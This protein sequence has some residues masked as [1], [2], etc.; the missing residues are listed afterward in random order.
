LII[1]NAGSFGSSITI[2]SATADALTFNQTANDLSLGG[3]I[4]GAGAMTKTG[5]GT[6]T[7]N[8]A[9]N[10]TGLTTIEEG[11]Y[12]GLN[13]Q[14]TLRLDFNAAGAPLNNIINNGADNSALYLG[15]STSSAAR[16]ALGGGILAINGSSAASV[17]NIQQFNGTTFGIGA[18]S[19]SI[20]NN[21]PTS[22]VKVSLG[23]LTR[24]PA[25]TVNFGQPTQ[26]TISATNGF[27]TASG[28]ASKILTDVNG[29]A[30]GVVGGTDWAAKDSGN[31]FVVSLSTIPGGYSAFSANGPLTANANIDVT[32]T[33][34]LTASSAATINSLRFNGG[35]S[36]PTTLSLTG[37]NTITTGGILFGS[38][39]ITA[40]TIQGGTIR[41]G[42]TGKELVIQN[43]SS[44][45][46]VISS[47]IADNGTTAVTLQAFNSTIGTGE[48][49]LTGANTYTGSTYITSG[50]ITSG[51][52][53]RPFGSSNLG[54]SVVIDGNTNAQYYQ[55][56]KISLSNQFFVVGAGWNET[57]GPNGVL[58]LDAG[59]ITGPVTML[60]D[61]TFGAV[62][63]TGTISGQIS[64]AYNLTKVGA[65]TLI[66]G[67][68][69]SFPNTYT[70]ATTVAA[71]TLDASSPGALPG[72]D[73]PGKAIVAGGATL[74]AAPG[75]STFHWT[76]ANIDTLRRNAAFAAGA[77][78]GID[79]SFFSPF[80]YGNISDSGNGPLGLVKLGAGILSL[81]ADTYSGGTTINAGTLQLT[82]VG[83]M[84]SPS[85]GLAL[86]GGVLD[87]NGISASVGAV[88]GGSGT[89]LNNATGTHATLTIGAA[90]FSGN[91]ASVIADNSS[92]TGT[93]RVSKVGAGVVN[94]QGV[95]TYSGGTS[96]SGGVLAVNGNT[97]SLNAASTLDF[98]NTGG[99]LYQGNTT[100]SS[101][102]FGALTLDAGDATVQSNYGGSGNTSL[103]FSSLT[104]TSGASGLLLATGGANGISNKI[105]L[106][107]AAPNALVDPGVFFGAGGGI[108]FAWCDP[109]GFVR[110]IS[111][112]TD[113]GSSTSAGSA[114]VS[115][116]YIQT[117]GPVTAQTTESL[118]TL[119][120]SGANDFTLADGASLTVAAILKTGDNGA[121][122]SGGA[123]IQAPGNGELVIR[124]GQPGDTL[125]ISTPIV[126]S[127][128]NALTV[129]GAGTLALNV[130]TSYSGATN[131]NN[132][133]LRLGNPGAVQNSTLILNNSSVLTFAPSIGTFTAGGLAGPGNFSLTDTDGGAV[134]LV[135]GGN[136][137]NTNFSGSMKGS[138]TLTK[139]GSGSLTLSGPNGYVGGTTV[140]GGMIVI[141]SDAIGTAAGTPAPLGALPAAG[142][143]ANN[144]VLNGGT[145]EANATF[146]INTQRGIGLGPAT[147]AVGGAGTIGV[148]A[149]NTL[150]Y[151]GTITTAGNTG[152]NQLAK[153]DL[154]TLVLS[155]SNSYTGGTMILGGTLVAGPDVTGAMTGAPAP[156][157]ALPAGPLGANNIILSGGTLQASTTYTLNA[158]RGIGLGPTTGTIGGSGT[159]DVA[160]G[161]TLTY[162]GAISS[163]G[164][165]GANQLTKADAGTLILGGPNTYTG[166]TNVQSGTLIF[167]SNAAIP[168]AGSPTVTVQNG[169]VVA[170]GSPIDQTFLSSITNTSSGFVALN[171]DSSGS[172][173]FSAAGANL[174]NVSLGAFSGSWTY[175]GAITPNN[176]N[177]R[178][179]GGGGVLTVNS[180]LSGANGLIV[181][182][183]GGAVLG[184]SANSFSGGITINSGATLGFATDGT[185]TGVDTP[186][187]AV[188]LALTS[189]IVI[190]NGTLQ[191]TG[192]SVVLNANR[193]IAVPDSIN[194]FSFSA[195]LTPS[196]I[197]TIDVAPSSQLTIPGAISGGGAL[198][199]TGL[200]TLILSGPNTYTGGTIV[201]AGTLT[202]AGGG[203]LGSPLSTFPA[204]TVNSS[205]SVSSA[206]NLSGDTVITALNGTVSGTGTAT[207]NVPA[208]S[209][210]TISQNYVASSTYAGT[211]AGAGGLTISGSGSF[212]V[213]LGASTYTG[214]TTVAGGIFEVTGG[215][216]L[217]SSTLIL[218]GGYINDTS[219]QMFSSTTLVQ[220][221]SSVVLRG[222]FGPIIRAMNRGGTPAGSALDVTGTTGGITTTTANTAGSILGGWATMGED[223]AVSAGDGM[224]AGA[225]TPLATYIANTWAPG[226]NVNVS[227]SNS[228]LPGSTT[229]SLN[230]RTSGAFTVTLS[231][232]NTIT[233]GGI[234]SSPA[235]GNNPSTITG[236]TLTS[237]NGTDLV[238]NQ[239]NNYSA[240]SP[241]IINSVI[242]GN[243]GL[244][245]A[246]NG[247]LILGGAN[248]YTG[249]T[250]IG[251]GTV[252][253]SSESA[254][255]GSLGTPPTAATASYSTGGIIING[256]ANQNNAGGALQAK[257]NITLDPNR[258]IYLGSVT[259]YGVGTID[260]TG[261]NTLSFGGVITN[262]VGSATTGVGTLIKA[263]TG[264]LNITGA[265]NTYSGGTIVV[266]GTLIARPD[267]TSTT[268]GTPAP[269]GA[270]PAPGLGA[271]NIAL[272]GGTLEADTTY[273][274]NALRGIGL[275]WRIGP[276][277]NG[278]GTIDVTSG[279]TLTFNGTITENSIVSF[280]P[281][282]LVKTDAGT[283]ILGG[284]NIYSGG[285]TV[286]GGTLRTTATGT[287]GSSSGPLV[288]SA[289]AGV[290]ST[291]SLGNSQTVSQLSGT[292][293]AGGS[294][295]INVAA[296]T[297]FAVNQSTQTTFSG[298]L[299]NSGT[300]TMSSSGSGRLEFTGTP[301]F[302]E[303]SLLTVTGG[304]L[305]FNVVSGSPTIGAGV[306]ATVSGSATLE[307]A[308]SVSALSSGATRVNITNNSAIPGVLASGTHQQVG[309]IDGTGAT[310][311]NAGSDLTANHIIQSALVIGGA[312]GS[313]GL[314]TIDASDASG[315]PLDQSSGLALAGPLTPNAPFGTDGIS[316][317]DL[318]RASGA[319]FA[320]M[321]PEDSVGVGN[322]SP[323]PEPSTLLLMLLAV[324]CVVGAQFVRHQSAV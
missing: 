74:A 110:A 143:G 47:I 288:V 276:T 28:T 3:T 245:K 164:N 217:A 157:G 225:V 94:F 232:N 48:I 202:V 323:V 256:N 75:S 182:A 279:N 166:G 254:T 198:R 273:T 302:S 179:G 306:A 91:F 283:L 159:I 219:T 250:Y 144:I 73:T 43:L 223:W 271:N 77:N 139:I 165:S 135:V 6:L 97:G 257:A 262:N 35:G 5:Y 98:G 158:L 195:L 204:L 24:K 62:N 9:T 154:G 294:A 282:A 278:A 163:A 76:S 310:Q 147:G 224:S 186:L 215:Y 230:F 127:G 37:T 261:A 140:L 251:C 203:T 50:R 20:T 120:V 90:N 171:A 21:N 66:F 17:N 319:D 292:V 233:S 54:T 36:T 156:L 87:L 88:A 71:G 213:L 86:N 322:L 299:V 318:S 92:G 112:G 173:D 119:N 293:G 212:Q 31:A 82:A 170:A 266:G 269:L 121:L 134:V 8:A 1:G 136:N 123:A 243:I 125:S 308:G 103:T 72:Y 307:L 155:G 239:E 101:Q 83:A 79:T 38:G 115:G 309:N 226:N 169:A 268:P 287:I 100:G 317:A 321:S 263:N 205:N 199:K 142:L 197:A 286:N 117:T 34:T 40:P 228:P 168:N 108:D 264:V 114:S 18:S 56:D 200:G 89:I 25:A 178:F 68:T 161:A 99:F 207:V 70:G 267:T 303:N 181:A 194:P 55:K 118:V 128:A 187:G 78:L 242:T 131:V 148:A 64:G 104:R 201:N 291:L 193:G 313:P 69:N 314:L 59:Q 27:Q 107:G 216:P 241:L 277:G 311:V 46:P 304:T 281:G 49:V 52:N 236:G 237:G 14:S 248:T 33:G 289:A 210:L 172:L 109:A 116:A 93:L 126:S 60:G 258:T 30:Y 180:L 297:T 19:L 39:L 2:N 124:T 209:T 138:G 235:A 65:G 105:V 137:A 229:N 275:G 12:S 67:A 244:T 7:L 238:V 196:N 255:G 295:T 176:S 132:G 111:Y 23:A 298:M 259:G 231:G 175:G 13:S 312:A 15:G 218:G 102:S 177:Y 11:A 22:T 95:N 211:I 29:V 81:G 80:P 152:D 45:A 26:G 53:S 42:S 185:T 63:G 280:L 174:A 221:G 191:S 153:N 133:I 130:A 150:T 214:P 301:T 260:V 190:N 149:G 320:V 51:P 189:N 300:V 227:A 145:L 141:G 265:S 162:N 61:S 188:P 106:T 151:N 192:S 208:G 285:T 183:A 290:T 234:L 10:Y 58:R 272:G 274:L 252:T 57:G 324:L 222:S 206:V 84:G 305:R 4:G 16:A 249:S 32:G 129:A 41:P 247:Q 246:G 113:P 220:G 122:I 284:N 253:I 96:I 315:N 44:Q 316:S 160:A 296:G 270:L 184:N 240:N 85:G 167:S 146:T